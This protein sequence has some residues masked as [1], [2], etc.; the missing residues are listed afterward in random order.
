MRGDPKLRLRFSLIMTAPKIWWDVIV[1][2]E[3]GVG[4]C[5]RDLDIGRATIARRKR[6]CRN[7]ILNAK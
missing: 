7:Y 4:P 6:L 1:L 5:S 3:P 2:H